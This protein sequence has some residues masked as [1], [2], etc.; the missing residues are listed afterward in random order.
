MKLSSLLFPKKTPMSNFPKTRVSSFSSADRMRVRERSIF[1]G[2]LRVIVL[3]LLPPPFDEQQDILN[4]ET[5]R[6]SPS[7]GWVNRFVDYS[8][9]ERLAQ[10]SFLVSRQ[11]FFLFSRR[12]LTLDLLSMM[13]LSVVSFYPLTL[14]QIAFRSKCRPTT[15]I[16]QERWSSQF[17]WFALTLA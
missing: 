8:W 5:Q 4:T 2:T 7:L 10:V 15:R 11:I 13:L 12:T 14:H 3:F 16:S 6:V 9:Q 1:K 17:S